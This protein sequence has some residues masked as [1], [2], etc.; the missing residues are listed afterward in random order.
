M[1]SGIFLIDKSQKL[2]M[3]GQSPLLASVPPATLSVIEALVVGMA[4]GPLPHLRI[5]LTASRVLKN[6]SYSTSDGV[7]GGGLVGR[8]GR[9]LGL[10]YPYE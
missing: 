6:S 3:K 4:A 2:T 5:C 1:S 7:L 10:G 8:L 9:L